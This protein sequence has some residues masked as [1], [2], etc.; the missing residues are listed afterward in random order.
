MQGNV[1]GPEFFITEHH[2]NPLAWRITGYLERRH[3]FAGKV[4]LDHGGLDPACVP[5]LV[6][7]L[8]THGLLSAIYGNYVERQV[9][10]IKAKT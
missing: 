4:R 5:Y 10:G 3:G 7:R 2:A 8:G 9:L 6:L 1:G